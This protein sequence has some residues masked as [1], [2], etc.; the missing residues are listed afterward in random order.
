MLKMNLLRIRQMMLFFCRNFLV[1]A[2]ASPLG[3]FQRTCL[4]LRVLARYHCL[5][6]ELL[7]PMLEATLGYDVPL[8]RCHW[9][10]R[11]L[12]LGYCGCMWGVIDFRGRPQRKDPFAFLSIS[13]NVGCTSGTIIPAL[14]LILRRKIHPVTDTMYCG[15]N[16]HLDRPRSHVAQIKLSDVLL[17]TLWTHLK[18]KIV[19]AAMQTSLSVKLGVGSDPFFAVDLNLYPAQE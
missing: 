19:I 14:R 17:R 6:K 8:L 4:H 10:F 11:I 3:A 9:R 16:G 1:Q 12:A 18:S 13:F 15:P 7:W 2:P 5:P